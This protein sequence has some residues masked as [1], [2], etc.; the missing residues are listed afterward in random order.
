[1]K[2]REYYKNTARQHVKRDRIQCWLCNKN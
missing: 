2:R 1:V